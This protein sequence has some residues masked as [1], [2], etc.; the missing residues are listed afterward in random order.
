[1]YF[2]RLK[3]NT[4]I[5]TRKPIAL[6]FTNL[7]VYNVWPE[8]EEHRG[9][10]YYFLS[11]YLDVVGITILFGDVFLIIISFLPPLFSPHSYF[12]LLFLLPLI[13]LVAVAVAVA[14]A[15]LPL[16]PHSHLV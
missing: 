4:R 7:L 8:E 16:P 11:C 9:Q 6:P 5:Y 13:V 15:L 14:V 3:E 10:I 1:M 12:L 2:Q